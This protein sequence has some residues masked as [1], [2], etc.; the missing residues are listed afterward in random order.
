MPYLKTPVLLENTTQ[1]DALL[2][3]LRKR[4]VTS[5]LLVCGNSITRMQKPNHFFQQLPDQGIT[6]TRF[7]QFSSNPDVQ[8]VERGTEVLRKAGSTAI[9]AVGGG[10]ALDVAKGIRIAAR[11]PLL[12]AIPTT[13][14][15]GSEA[16]PYAVLY[17]NGQKESITREDCIPDYVLL[18]P[19]VLDTLPL[20]QR[21]ATM[22]D[23][24]SHCIESMWSFHATPNSQALS[25]KGIQLFWQHYSGYLENMPTDNAGM[26]QAAFLGGQAI[27]ITQTTAAHAMSYQLTIRY[28][29]AH[30]HAVGLCLLPVWKQLARKK[31]ADEA[32]KQLQDAF[33]ARSVPEA[34]A[35][36]QQLLQALDLV[37]PKVTEH[38]LAD[39]ACSANPARLQNHP[40]SLG[41]QDLLK[42]YQEALKV[43][44]T[45]KE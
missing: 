29:I 39:L 21:K 15:S 40:I 14:G 3:V 28:G 11:I 45:T 41:E 9:C 44:G 19:S 13:A 38:A 7:S 12:V 35:Q 37:P 4:Q 6:V 22:L 10:S 8:A 27:A 25:R 2:Q 18:D 42:L 26:Q 30:G 24:L 33:G 5:L 1:Y 20:Y 36:Y 43:P 16:T 34:V 17:R 31:V 23:A 32:L